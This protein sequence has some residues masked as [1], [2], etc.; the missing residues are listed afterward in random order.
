MNLL[1]IVIALT[2]GIIAYGILSVLLER[3]L[4]NKR[5]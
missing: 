3:L 4:L 1:R 2:C 5:R